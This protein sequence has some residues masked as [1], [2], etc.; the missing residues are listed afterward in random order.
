MALNDA[1]IPRRIRERYERRLK[2][3]VASLNELGL[4]AT[5]PGGTYFLMV[6]APKGVK[7][8]P[9]FA[10][11]EEASQYLIKEH[12][13]CTV[14][15]EEGEMLRFSATFVA[16]TEQDEDRYMSDLKERLR[17]VEFVW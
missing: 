14:P 7:N 10:N 17:G 16:P 15:Y 6:K 13:I 12:M 11:A 9:V 1:D 8:G 4:R 3:M 2:K 5:M